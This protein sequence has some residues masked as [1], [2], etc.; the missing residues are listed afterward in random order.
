MLVLLVFIDIH[1]LKVL[2]NLILYI[3]K[4]RYLFFE[5]KKR[6]S[7]IIT[8]P[9]NPPICPKLSTLGIENPS[10]KL[11]TITDIILFKKFFPAFFPICISYY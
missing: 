8:P 10:I 11:T 5:Y 9:I 1:S 3:L 7:V 4:F 6:T 2:F